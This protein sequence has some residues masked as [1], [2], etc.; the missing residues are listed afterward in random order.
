MDLVQVLS[1]L[2]CK[3][4]TITKLDIDNIITVARDYITMLFQNILNTSQDR[5]SLLNFPNKIANNT[6]IFFEPNIYPHTLILDLAV[7]GQNQKN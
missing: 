6:A 2:W 3:I 7:N 4:R 1:V 5:E